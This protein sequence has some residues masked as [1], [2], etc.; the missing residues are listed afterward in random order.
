MVDI[1]TLKKAQRYA[2]AHK[3]FGYPSFR[4]YQGAS[5]NVKKVNND[6]TLKGNFTHVKKWN[7]NTTA[8][9]SKFFTVKDASGNNSIAFN[10]MT[11][12]TKIEVKVNGQLIYDL[13]QDTSIFYPAGLGV[14]TQFIEVDYDKEEIRISSEQGNHALQIEGLK[15]LKDVEFTDIEL[16]I[17]SY[18]KGCMYSFIIGGLYDISM[19]SK[20][21]SQDVPVASVNGKTV[22]DI[23]IGEATA[24]GSWSTNKSFIEGK[25]IFEYEDLSS[26]DSG[27]NVYRVHRPA[28]YDQSKIYSDP[29]KPL[30][31]KYSYSLDVENASIYYKI[32]TTIIP[33]RAR[34]IEKETDQIIDYVD[35]SANETYEIPPGKW[36]V[37]ITARANF[38]T[39]GAETL[40]YTNGWGGCDEGAKMTVYN[41]AKYEPQII[42]L[43]AFPQ[44]ASFDLCYC[45]FSNQY[46]KGV[47][48]FSTKF[49]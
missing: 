9:N 36:R 49:E 13:S 15:A 43:S 34:L 27:S 41:D 42:I 25:V 14:L 35:K 2:D 17:N 45:P 12:T 8:V 5:Y 26:W 28:A 11:Y 40:T 23:A 39:Y 24:Y 33:I 18:R 4:I 21:I 32:P 29:A 20:I 48:S 31:I 44:M 46:V 10:N 3:G 37:E 47:W 1:L 38:N 30:I 19:A 22:K 16:G 7:A 6:F